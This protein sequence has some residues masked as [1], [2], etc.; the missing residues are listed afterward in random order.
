M[1]NF[2][3]DDWGTWT[4]GI[5]IVLMA[6][7]ILLSTETFPIQFRRRNTKVCPVFSQLGKS[8]V[9]RIPWSHPLLALRNPQYRPTTNHVAVCAS[10]MI[11][12]DTMME[13]SLPALYENV[14]EP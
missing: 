12:N 13:W 10:G 6:V 4:R 14:I 9:R 2:L 5:V 1:V 3:P 11:P 8:P 7:V